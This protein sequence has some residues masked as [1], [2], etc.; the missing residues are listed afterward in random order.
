MTPENS[1]R[2]AELSEKIQN[3]LQQ[4]EELAEEGR[5][6]ESQNLMRQV[7]QLKAE[8]EQILSTFNDPRAVSTQEKRMK[9]CEICGAF[10][11]VGD[12]EKRVSSHMEGKQHQ[13]YALIR[14]TLEDYRKFFK[15][16]D[17][18]ERDRKYRGSDRGRYR[19]DRDRDY[20]RRDDEF[21][22]RRDYDDKRDYYD[23]R[24]K[25]RDRDEERRKS[26]D[27][28]EEK[29]ESPEEKRNSTEPERKKFR[30]NY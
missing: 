23:E 12:T 9:V 16:E 8:K 30:E 6:T 21:G 28:D 11:V 18:K 15:P 25:S 17:T 7:D 27:R 4:V 22:R 26:R 29:K 1:Q 3:L 5:V 20:R 19:R 10:L 2:M 13:G 14:K 24:R